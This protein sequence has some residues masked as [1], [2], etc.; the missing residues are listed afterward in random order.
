V[1]PFNDANAP[2]GDVVLA[3]TSRQATALLRFGESCGFDLAGERAAD[4]LHIS[5]IAGYEHRQR[6]TLASPMK[7]YRDPISDHVDDRSFFDSYSLPLQPSRQ[8]LRWRITPDA[9][10]RPS[11]LP[12][13]KPM[14]SIDGSTG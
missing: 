13:L 6:L 4:A 9:L 8:I 12:N 5:S 11:N 3:S 1:W 14:E 2:A 10:S 7:S